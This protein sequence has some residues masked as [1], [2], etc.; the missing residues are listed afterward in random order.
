[1][2][3]AANTGFRFFDLPPELRSAIF[4]QLLVADKDSN[5]ILHGQTLSRLPL[6]GPK[7]ALNVFYVNL[8]MYQEAS[9]IFYSQNHFIINA[10]SHRLPSHL[11]EQGGFLDEQARDARRRVRNLT[12]YLTRVGGEFENVLGP[13]L[14]DMVLCGS[15]RELR[16]RLGQQS[17]RGRNRRP[18]PDMVQRPPF[19]ALLRLLADP[20]L[21]TVELTAWKVHCPV[22]CPFHQ[23]VNSESINDDGLA[24][25]ADASWV[26][27]D[28]R[29]MVDV[30][31]TG[32]QIMRVGERL[33]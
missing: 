5:I 12:L 25:L 26:Q 4:S 3:M 8:Q 32:Q 19:Q 15:L 16:V 11:T 31:G 28:W 6:S 21:Q 9:A 1:M 7:S 13:A 27:L 2:T 24:T 17:W 18:D 23:E 33:Y 29:A 14:S 22:L 20:D 30:H 10:Q